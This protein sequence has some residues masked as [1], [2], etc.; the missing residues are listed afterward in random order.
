MKEFKDDRWIPSK[1]SI[2]ERVII[3]DEFGG[4]REETFLGDNPRNKVVITSHNKRA[5]VDVG[6]TLTVT[7]EIQD[8]EGNK[9]PFNDSF[10]MPV[11]RVGGVNYRTLM[12][13]FSEGVCTKT[14]VWNDAGEFE[15][16][17]AMINTHLN[18]EQ[19]LDFKG[20][21]VSVAE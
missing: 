18:K 19:K 15:I 5:L 3:Y 13:T 9:L 16:T 11:G 14:A 12:M 7:V 20:F 10:A 4:C 1:P 6:G 2:G 8:E 21:T 17:E